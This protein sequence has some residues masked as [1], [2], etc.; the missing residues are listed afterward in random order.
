MKDLSKEEY[1]RELKYCYTNSRWEFSFYAVLYMFLLQFRDEY[2]KLILCADY[3]SRGRRTSAKMKRILKLCSVKLKGKNNQNLIGGIPDFQFVPSNYTYDEPCEA[4]V[5]VEF[6][7]PNF[8]NEDLYIP[9]KYEITP[10]IEH[11]F[12][13]C[14]KIIFTDGISWYFLEKNKN[15]QESPFNLYEGD[16][17]W[18]QLKTKIK[19]FIL[20]ETD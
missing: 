5:F 12:E 4:K 2:N 8:S 10:E 3:K 14:D 9:L 13:N 17:N 20:G 7:S 15:K 16:D 18:E 19:H 1:L 6:K 11:E